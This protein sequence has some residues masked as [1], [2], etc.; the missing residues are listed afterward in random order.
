VVPVDSEAAAPVELET[1]SSPREAGLAAIAKGEERARRVRKMEAVRYFAC[2]LIERLLREM[3][4][5]ESNNEF[6]RL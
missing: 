6:S 1:D 4:K 3:K 2:I 5:V